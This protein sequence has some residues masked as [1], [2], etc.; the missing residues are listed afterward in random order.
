MRL[1]PTRLRAPPGGPTATDWR[2]QIRRVVVFVGCLGMKHR[3]L[4]LIQG[5]ADPA[6]PGRWGR[7]LRGAAEGPVG[8]VSLPGG[9]RRPLEGVPKGAW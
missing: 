8:W 4:A 1:P 9:R 5:A 3:V 7:P 2:S 6:L